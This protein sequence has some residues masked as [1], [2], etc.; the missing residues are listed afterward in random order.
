MYKQH[1]VHDVLD[2][3]A[4]QAKHVATEEE[5]NSE[6]KKKKVGF[7]FFQLPSEVI[8]KIISYLSAEQLSV[9]AMTSK[10]WRTYVYVP[11]HWKALAKRIWRDESARELERRMVFNYKTWRLLVIHRPHVRVQGYYI[12]RQSFTKTSTR[13]LSDRPIAPVFLVTW[14]RWLRFYNDGTVVQLTTPEQLEKA[15]LRVKKSW[16][17][18]P[19]QV[20]KA[21]PSIGEYN[22]DEASNQVSVKIQMVPEQYPGMRPVTLFSRFELDSTRPGSFDILRPVEH[23]AVDNDTGDTVSFNG[24]FGRENFQFVSLFGFKK[25]VRNYFPKVS[26]V[27]KWTKYASGN[28]LDC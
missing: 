11:A 15:Y 24:G 28:E 19:H 2:M 23:F 16:K 7:D 9:L 12:M 21:Y 3:T 27:E 13:I 5:D 6:P 8:G 25:N 4:K 22:F 1:P 10:Y 14:H 17:P 26:Q 18:L 20:N